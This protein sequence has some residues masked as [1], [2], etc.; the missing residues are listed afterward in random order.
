M[1]A[2][3]VHALLNRR[4]HKRRKPK[5]LKP[6]RFPSST[7]VRY[8]AEL[9]I[10]L[11][12]ME[13][14][15]LDAVDTVMPSAVAQADVVRADSPTSDV[16]EIMAALRLK[17][18]N[19]LTDEL[20]EELAMSI[21]AEINVKNLAEFESKFEGQ[22]LIPGISPGWTIAQGQVFVA[23]NVSLIKSLTEDTWGRVEGIMLRGLQSGLRVEGMEQQIRQA[24]GVSRSRAALIARDQVGKAQGQINQQRQ[25]QVGVEEFIWST[26]QDERV[27][28]SHA[29]VNGKKFRWDNPPTIDGEVATPG[30]PV[31]CRC[32]AIPVIP[33]FE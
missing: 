27:R 33:E 23:Q 32:S 2:A 13:K 18:G 20:L 12:A 28:S 9:H 14:D 5:K 22:L 15:T 19:V 31:R 10:L 11:R 17:Y 4:P 29:A 8:T 30:S 6:V 24:F 26:S 21:Y 7:V 1:H 16:Q 3:Q 25:R